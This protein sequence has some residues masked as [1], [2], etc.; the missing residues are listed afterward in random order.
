[1]VLVPITFYIQSDAIA[2]P[3]RNIWTE[4]HCHLDFLCSFWHELVQDHFSKIYDCAQR[5]QLSFLHPARHQVSIL[6][7]DSNSCAEVKFQQR[8]A[9]MNKTSDWWLDLNKTSTVF[10]FRYSWKYDDQNV[11]IKDRDSLPNQ[12]LHCSSVQRYGKV[13]QSNLCL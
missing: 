5:N 10:L 2:S 6:C 12:S 9:S 11:S 4:L 13:Y 8:S 1:M 3:R 7:T